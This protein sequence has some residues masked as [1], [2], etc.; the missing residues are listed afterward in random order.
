[1]TNYDRIDHISTLPREE[2]R[3][4]LTCY[5]SGELEYLFA[6]AR[7][8]REH[9]YGRAVYLRGLIEFSSYCKK[10]CY[11]CGLRCGNRSAKRFRLRQD[12]IL[13]CCRL[14][15]SPG[16]RTFVLQSGE[17][18]YFDDT[19]MVPIVQAIRQE[20][21]DCAI[22]LSLGER[23]R[24][25]YQVLFDAGAN[26]YLLRHEAANPEHYAKLHPA[27]MRLESRLHCLQSL[28][29]IGFQVGCGFMVGSPGQTIECL[30]DDLAFLA[31]F[32]PEMVGI[33][34]FLPHSATLFAHEPP[35]TMEQTLLL[36]AITRLL[37]PNA[38]L[39]ATTALGSAH[40]QGRE[41]ALLAGA[42]VIMPNLSPAGAQKQ[43]VLYDGKAGTDADIADAL[44]GVKD[45][46]ERVGYEIA[47]SRGDPPPH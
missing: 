25:S 15:Y 18:P 4:L 10:N 28:R 45:C 6:K 13:D 42:N 34:P 37:L 38:L 29:E 5:N 9:T 36:L 7:A 20:F 17:D 32:R 1:M 26:R 8:A 27:S 21:P 39:P 23:S 16:I 46:V 31:A 24:E 33:G 44:R 22:T 11:Y 14:G 43:Y 30:L 41:K 47:V 40:P 35:G 12:E 19:R 3:A 2:M